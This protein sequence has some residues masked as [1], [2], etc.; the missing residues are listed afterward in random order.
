MGV[1]VQV[2]IRLI[3]DLVN[4]RV[5]EWI[6]DDLLVLRSWICAFWEVY[7]CDELGA[8]VHT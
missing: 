1:R 4:G 3:A 6:L 5:L 2:P 7:R 8:L